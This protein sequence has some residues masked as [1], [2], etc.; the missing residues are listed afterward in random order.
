M[1]SPIMP[2][3]RALCWLVVAAVVIAIALLRWGDDLLIASDTVPAHVDAAIVLQ[4]SI[5]AEKARIAGAIDLLRRGVADRALL[6]VPKESYWGQS[7]PP[8]ARSYLERNYGSDLAARV[9]FCETGGEVNSTA[10]EVQA[11]GPCV[12]EHHWQSIVIVTSD[13]HT[14]RAGML[15]RRAIVRDSKVHIWIEGV[16]DPE[17]QQPWWRHRQSAKIWLM[18]SSKLAWTTLGG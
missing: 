18:E 7:I 8:A 14:R 2:W 10:Q 13:Y 11:L 5:A 3:I 4:G 12:Q 9:D 1:S 6:S 17:F 16:A 15:W